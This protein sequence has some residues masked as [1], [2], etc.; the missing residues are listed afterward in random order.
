M[1]TTP[2][3]SRMSQAALAA[4][5]AALTEK[6][7]ALRQASDARRREA[8]G[9]RQ[10]E[11]VLSARIAT[12]ERIEEAA[13]RTVLAREERLRQAEPT[14]GTLNKE[15]DLR[16]TDDG[17]DA[18]EEG[19]QALFSDVI[20]RPSGSRMP[21]GNN[22]EA[23]E[24]SHACSTAKDLQGFFGAQEWWLHLARA[25]SDNMKDGVARPGTHD[26]MATGKENAGV[27]R[28]GTIERLRQLL[29]DQA[30]EIVTLRQRALK[31][32]M[33]LRVKAGEEEERA[34]DAGRRVASLEHAL[35]TR[36][37]ADSTLVA[38]LEAQVTVLRVRGELHQA[39]ATAREE[40][41]AGKLAVIRAE[42]DANLHAQLLVSYWWCTGCLCGPGS[43]FRIWLLLNVELFTSKSGGAAS[44][45]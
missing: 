1:Y 10:R 27:D 5:T 4:Q 7:A 36:E 11:E 22:G 44:S 40:A 2:S 17:G 23:A 24:P 13:R 29:H 8:E 45:I 9:A 12:L 34:M 21:E 30:L 6:E 14:L 16:R 33:G 43:S 35:R 28:N 32:E 37:R 19:V 38:E 41:T 39:L 18:R 15:A 31:A 3:V 42:G 25:T 26:S 20:V